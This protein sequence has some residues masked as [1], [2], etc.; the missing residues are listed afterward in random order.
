MTTMLPAASNEHLQLNVYFAW[1][2]DTEDSFWYSAMRE[3]VQRL[4]GVAKQEGIY[5]D[6]KYP[7]YAATGT[8]AE[9]LYGVANARRLRSIRNQIDPDKVMELAGGFSI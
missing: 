5:V 7:N 3:S 2:F 8:P 9:L 4:V 1:A 6:S